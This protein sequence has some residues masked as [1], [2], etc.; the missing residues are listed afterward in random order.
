MEEHQL[1]QV[2]VAARLVSRSQGATITELAKAMGVS[3]R[4]AYRRKEILEELKYP[5][6]SEEKNGEVRF[7]LNDDIDRMRWWQ[8]L[9]KIAFTFEDTVLLEYLF[10]KA[11]ENPALAKSV[12]D[13]RRKIAPL[14]ADGGYSIAEKEF[15]AGEALKVVPV[16]ISDAPVAKKLSAD[17]QSFIRVLLQSVKEKSVCVVGYDAAC[18]GT[19]RTFRIEPLTI[20][21]HG[22]G[23]YAYVFQPYYGNIIVL[24]LERIRS[25]ELTEDSFE[26]PPGFDPV[27]LLS[28]PF[29]FV[30]ENESFVARVLFDKDQAR[31][32][33][34]REWPDGTNI[35][36]NSDGSIVLTV[37]TSGKYE[38]IRWLMGYGSAAE[39]LEPDWL[40]DEMAEEIARMNDRY[41]H[42]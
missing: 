18:N 28:D 10:T 22:G 17:T 1:T 31:Y 42:V 9:P 11:S 3:V 24:A 32:V 30:L 6:Y 37:T 5:L 27:K 33:T 34:E 41:T 25:L 8:P 16:I 15:G 35:E 20:F 36:K 2:L 13:L 12:K 38:L 7:Y 4:T 26:P 21:E 23:L 14:V 39:V 19:V 29:G 40:R